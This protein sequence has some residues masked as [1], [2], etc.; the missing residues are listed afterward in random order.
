MP[1]VKQRNWLLL[2]TVL[3]LIGSGIVLFINAQRNLGIGVC[4]HNDVEYLQGDVVPNYKEGTDCH[5]AIS[6]KIVCE[7]DSI[8]MSYETFSS[9]GLTF[10]YGFQNFLEKESPDLTRIYLSD[11]NQ[12]ADSLE[13]ILERE[14][15]CDEAGLAPVQVGMYEKNT[16]NLVLTT[17]T[18]R[19][20]SLYSRVCVVEN[21]FDVTNIDL[22]GVESYSVLY[23]GEGGELYDLK[24]CYFNN[25]LYAKGEV[26]KDSEKNRLCTCEGPEL[27]CEDL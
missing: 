18:N 5:C 13:I 4:Y 1:K 14:A 3:L 6:G 24:V 26:F 10:S 25:K 15:L 20:E 22:S 7:S 19:D 23:Q 12:N 27:S 8:G 17:I 16:D 9:A 2:I 11:I 21:K